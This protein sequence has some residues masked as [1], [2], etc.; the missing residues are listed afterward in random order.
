MQ[1]LQPHYYTQ[2]L[3]RRINKRGKRRR[4]R[5][6]KRHYSKMKT[7]I[8]KMRTDIYPELSLTKRNPKQRWQLIYIQLNS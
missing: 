8:T 5:E 3:R 4:T 6:R 7:G 1:N 2:N